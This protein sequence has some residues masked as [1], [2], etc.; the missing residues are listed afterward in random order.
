MEADMKY[1]VY[2]V[3]AHT[4]VNQPSGKLSTDIKSHECQVFVLTPS[5][6]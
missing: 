4:A 5:G 6:K 1:S 3:W 2:D